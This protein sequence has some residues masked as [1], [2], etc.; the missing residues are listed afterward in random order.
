MGMVARC[1][2]FSVV[3]SLGL[4]MLFTSE[5][6]LKTY[7]HHV[8]FCWK[9]GSCFFKILTII[10]SPAEAFSRNMQPLLGSEG[11]LELRAACSWGPRNRRFPDPYLQYYRLPYLWKFLEWNPH[12]GWGPACVRIPEGFKNTSISP[13]LWKGRLQHWPSSEKPAGGMPDSGYGSLR[14]YHDLPQPAIWR[15]P[16]RLQCTDFG[17]WIGGSAAQTGGALV[18]LAYLVICQC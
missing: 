4:R 6:F 3:A 16:Q 9:T 12:G 8:R 2:A 14:L 15:L 1:R 5:C 17:C 13:G 11:P 10:L 18:V 7:K